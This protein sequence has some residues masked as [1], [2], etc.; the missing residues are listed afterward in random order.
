MDIQRVFS[1]IYFP[2]NA[3]EKAVS[4]AIK[5]LISEGWKFGGVESGK[6]VL[7][8]DWEYNPITASMGG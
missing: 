2:T 1:H 5:S 4:L 3:D 6:V 7:S 8:R